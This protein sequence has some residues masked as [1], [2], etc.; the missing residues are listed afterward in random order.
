MVGPIFN[1]HFVSFL[2]VFFKNRKQY[3]FRLL[4]LNLRYAFYFNILINQNVN[5]NNNRKYCSPTETK[6]NS[7][8][9]I[10]SLVA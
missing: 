10:Y 4:L 6:I 7:T 2:V 9:Y 8:F 3:I 5:K 1:I